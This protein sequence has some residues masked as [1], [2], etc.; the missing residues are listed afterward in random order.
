MTR[1]ASRLALKYRLTENARRD[2]IHAFV[3]G[4]TAF[5]VDQAERYQDELEHAFELIADNPQLA[6]ERFEISPPVR[7]H[8]CGSHLIIY[9]L[10]ADGV[11]IVGVRHHKEN[12]THNPYSG[13]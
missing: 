8:P 10:D 5:G 11:L 2:L 3:E 13:A 6:R 4:V 12:W 9:I 7:V 1:R